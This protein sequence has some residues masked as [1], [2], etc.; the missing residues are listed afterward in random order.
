MNNLFLLFVLILISSCTSTSK[1]PIPY[2][3]MKANFLQAIETNNPKVTYQVVNSEKDQAIV[4]SFKTNSRD[5]HQMITMKYSP[6]EDC[7]QDSDIEKQKLRPLGFGPGG[8]SFQLTFCASRY[9]ITLVDSNLLGEGD[10]D[11]GLDLHKLAHSIR[12]RLPKN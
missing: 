5:H 10:M 8:A 2:S 4:A 11:H 12:S 6:S 3:E 9:Q 7:R 1:V